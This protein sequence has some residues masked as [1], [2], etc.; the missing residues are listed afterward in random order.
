MRASLRSG[1]SSKIAVVHKSRSEL[2]NASR[3]TINATYEAG[4]LLSSKTTSS[5]VVTGALIRLSTNLESII[6][7]YQ[8]NE[9]NDV[10]KGK[11]RS[12]SEE[13]AEGDHQEQRHIDVRGPE[14]DGELVLTKRDSDSKEVEFC[15]NDGGEYNTCVR[16]GW[17]VEEGWREV[18]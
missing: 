1:T 8:T 2:S 16:I 14:L 11:E 5:T 18:V 3:V 4:D 17:G 13:L 6:S 15:V 12:Q 9:K 10:P 7:Q